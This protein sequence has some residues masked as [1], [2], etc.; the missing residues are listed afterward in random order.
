M[1]PIEGIYWMPDDQ[2]NKMA[3]QFKRTLSE[4]WKNDGLDDYG[5][6]IFREGFVIKA[7][8]L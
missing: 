2:W 7:W 3:W 4:E 8:T 6:H 1:E 5:Q